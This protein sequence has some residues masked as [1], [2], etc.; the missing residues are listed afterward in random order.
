MSRQHPWRAD[1]P[2]AI[3]V[4]RASKYGN[5]CVWANRGWYEPDADGYMVFHRA[6]PARARA[7]SVRGFRDMLADPEARAINHYPTDDEI[8]ADLAG[9]D[10]ACWCGPN[11]SCHGDVLLSIARGEEP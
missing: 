8:R 11:D 10:L 4:D 5:P 7:I 1:N 2:D 3:R 9:H 6:D